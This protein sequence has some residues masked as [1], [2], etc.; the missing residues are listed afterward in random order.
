MEAEQ[1]YTIVNLLAQQSLGM[2]GLTP[3]KA[4]FIAV[5]QEVLAN[6]DNTEKWFNKLCDRIGKTI[7]DVRPYEAKGNHLTRQGIDYGIILQKIYVDIKDAEANDTFTE[8]NVG[9]DQFE[10]FADP[11]VKQWFFKSKNVWEFNQTIGDR[12]I[13]DAFTSAEAMGAMWEAIMVALNNAVEL[14]HENLNNLC[15]ATY[16]ARLANAADTNTYVNLLAEYN[17]QTNASLTK[18]NCVYDHDFLRYAS[19]RMR[20]YAGYMGDMSRLF[21]PA[22][23]ARFTS[24]DNMALDIIS[25]FGH[26]V[27][28]YLYSK[29]L[30]ESYVK[31]PEYTPI[32]YWQGSGLSYGFDDVTGIKVALSDTVTVDA[33]GIVAVLYDKEAMGTLFER[34]KTKSARNERKEWTNYFFKAET[35][36]YNDMSQNGIVFYIAEG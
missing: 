23:A 7:I 14:A 31:L 5:G 24:P 4:S 27:E 36:Y 29:T 18:A 2:K 10:R 13:S 9:V 33:N 22:K 25:E 32:S 30:H 15:R 11:D 17:T 28:S 1:I 26:R 35:G 20:L 21:N 6:E 19:M 16:I 12:Q 3:T 34:R 8:S